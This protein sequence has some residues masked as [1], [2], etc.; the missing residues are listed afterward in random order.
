MP[1]MTTDEKPK[2]DKMKFPPYDGNPDHLPK[3]KLIGKRFAEGESRYFMRN[4]GNGHELIRVFH[5]GKAISTRMVGMIKDGPKGEILRQQ[6]L[7][8]GVKILHGNSLRK[9][10]ESREL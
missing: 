7:K 1:T 5:D 2:V 9:D 6:V 8:S 10:S 4:A 3:G